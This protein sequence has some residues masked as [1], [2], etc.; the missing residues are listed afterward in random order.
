MDYTFTS[1]SAKITLNKRGARKY[2]RMS[3]PIYC[4]C[5]N[6]IETRDYLLH[7]NLNNEILRAKGKGSGWPHPHE[8]LKRNMGNDWIYYSTGGYTG[9]YEAT[10]EYYLPNMPY[11]T[12]GL[13]GG[14]PFQLKEVSDLIST[15]PEIIKKGSARLE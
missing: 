2:T 13:I 12:N 5:F 8:W 10:G 4:G 7:F 11:V 6:E 9:V 15:W 1:D 3:Y 14:N